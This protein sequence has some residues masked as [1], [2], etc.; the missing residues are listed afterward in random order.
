MSQFPSRNQIIQQIGKFLYNQILFQKFTLIRWRRDVFAIDLIFFD[1]FFFYFAWG[2]SWT[3]IINILRL[4]RLIW[5][6]WN[7]YWFFDVI[8][9][10][11]I[12]FLF[13]YFRCRNYKFLLP[14][15]CGWCM[16]LLRF[17]Y[18]FCFVAIIS[19]RII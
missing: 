12:R 7:F 9:C 5:R 2:I 15:L 8:Y 4:I 13:L 14:F 6:L 11:H 3:Q 1:E 17:V 18:N 10:I 16:F 19:Q